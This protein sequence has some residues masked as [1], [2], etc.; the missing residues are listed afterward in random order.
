ML[1]KFWIYSEAGQRFE[2]R[3]TSIVGRG[4]IG[5]GTG[6][7]VGAKLDLTIRQIASGRV[8]PHPLFYRSKHNYS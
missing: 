8:H 2:I 1:D 5:V 6:V 3:G 7:G 4:S